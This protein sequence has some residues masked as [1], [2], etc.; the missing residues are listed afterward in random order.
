VRPL[1]DK[2]TS[3]YSDALSQQSSVGA[4]LHEHY[5]SGATQTLTV[6][7]GDLLFAAVYIYPANVPSEIMLQWDN[8]SWEHRAYW[9]GDDL[10]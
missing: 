2:T 6:N 10:G 4:D 8:G 1:S 3:P 7:A 5:F 9:G